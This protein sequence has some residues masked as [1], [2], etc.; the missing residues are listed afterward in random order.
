MP[1][2]LG[3]WRA[4][5]VWRR[6]ERVRLKRR[7]RSRLRSWRRRWRACV[8]LITLDCSFTSS[9]CYTN[10]LSAP[11]A[12]CKARSAPAYGLWNRYIIYTNTHMHVPT[13]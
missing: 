12:V 3:C 4:V 5:W 7:H 1:K 10:S 2:R 6:R 8:V 13:V 11:S 9:S